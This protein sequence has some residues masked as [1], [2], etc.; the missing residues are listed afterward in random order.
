MCPKLSFGGGGPPIGSVS[1]GYNTQQGFGLYMNRT[2]STPTGYPV[3][4]SGG[5]F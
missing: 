2:P 4:S 3:V 5:L 1:S